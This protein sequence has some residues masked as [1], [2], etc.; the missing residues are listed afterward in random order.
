MNT[1][2]QVQEI[3]Q[4]ASQETKSKKVLLGMLRD[5]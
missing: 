5:G 2:N 4:K 1:T 3:Y